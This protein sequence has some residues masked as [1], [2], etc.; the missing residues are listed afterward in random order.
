M[1]AL[2]AKQTSKQ[3]ELNDRFCATL[4]RTGV[5]NRTSNTVFKHSVSVYCVEHTVCPACP[6]LVLSHS[7]SHTVI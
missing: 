2:S 4:S 7:F 5:S 1:A 3:V 6:T